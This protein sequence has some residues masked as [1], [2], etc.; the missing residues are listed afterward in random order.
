MKPT[1]RRTIIIITLIA[2][3]LL[4][5]AAVVHASTAR[6]AAYL[7][8]NATYSASDVPPEPEKDT[9]FQCHIT[10][11]YT[12]LWTAT[13]RWAV[14]GI[15]GLIFLFG[16]VRSVSVWRTR[17]AWKPIPTRVMEWVDERY[18]LS[19]FLEPILSKPVPDWQR[20]WWY[21]LGGLTFFFFT[22]QGATGIML[23]FYYKATPEAAYAS[24]QFI[25]NEVRLG[26]AVRA[27]HHWSANGMIVMAVA[28]MLRV[29]IMGAY[30]KPRE[31]NWIS[32]VVL[33]ITTLAFGFTG[34]L[35]PWDQR[36]YWATTVGSAIAGGIPVIG[37]LSLVLLRAGWN[38]T[39]LTLTRFYSLHVLVIPLITVGAML[40]HFIM[41][42]KQ[43]VMKPL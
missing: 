32:G 41:I 9:C 21:C 20:R 43:G 17:E 16:V 5:S 18:Q 36:A 3:F 23:T 33:L 37:N 42:R 8:G 6:E 40:M 31:L 39:A 25:E 38:V 30:K 12:N 14:F 34:Y 15:A 24:I 4:F 1:P 29:F 2:V 19:E 13:A 27:I 28:H 26:A 10:G 35:L 7:Q 11:E 22:I